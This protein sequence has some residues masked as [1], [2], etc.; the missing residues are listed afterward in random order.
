MPR[1]SKNYRCREQT[2]PEICK[3]AWGGYHAV[4][5]F[6]EEELL[7]LMALARARIIRAF[8]EQFEC[9]R[10]HKRRTDNYIIG[11]RPKQSALADWIIE[12]HKSADARYDDGK[13]MKHFIEIALLPERLRYLDQKWL[14]RLVYQL[15]RDIV[16]MELNVMCG[17]PNYEIYFLE[18]HGLWQLIQ[19]A[20]D[21]YYTQ[22]TRI[23][24]V[25][26]D[27]RN[28][29]GMVRSQRKRRGRPAGV[30]TSMANDLRVFAS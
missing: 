14:E 6:S 4:D 26:D 25:K 16:L 29:H 18:S 2:S 13:R 9:Y 3:I 5:L 1:R 12:G 21:E 23:R 20:A 24:R 10:D 7:D 17:M 27:R 30:S 19:S 28:E 22:K 11:V 15:E 8:V